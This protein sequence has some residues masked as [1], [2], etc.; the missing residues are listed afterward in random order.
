[1][2]TKALP[3]MIDSA[4]APVDGVAGGLTA[5][6]ILQLT[7]FVIAGLET[8]VEEIDRTL[9]LQQTMAGDLSNHAMT[10]FAAGLPQE[11]MGS[12][13]GIIAA[14]QADDRLRQRQ[15][16]LAIALGVLAEAAREMETKATLPGNGDGTAALLPD[17]W[18]SQALS[19]LTME[20]VKSRFAKRFSPTSFDLD[21]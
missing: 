3:E 1:M 9:E 18:V 11:A 13:S 21:D 17:R 15:S 8:A 5:D 2:A 6:E 7:G 4:D 12:V 10:L 20:E 16:N 14:L 19:Q